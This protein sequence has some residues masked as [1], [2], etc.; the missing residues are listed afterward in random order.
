MLRLKRIVAFHRGP[1][2]S[3]KD[4]LGLWLALFAGA[5]GSGCSQSTW[6]TIGAIATAAS[7]ASAAQGG[8]SAF[9]P[10]TELLIFGGQDHKTFLGCLNCSASSTSSVLNQ[11]SQYGSSYS[12]SSIFNKYGIF[13]SA[14][15][16]YGVCSTYAT[17]PPV[18]VNRAGGY[19]GR[20]TLNTSLSDAVRDD[21]VHAWLLGV[22]H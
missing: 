13:G 16:N 17:D 21:R 4:Q 12:A 15:S 9:A 20:L 8:T 18:I 22:C 3:S 7:Q 5:V 19:F 10:G 11:Y 6:Q 1:N 14:Y 2:A